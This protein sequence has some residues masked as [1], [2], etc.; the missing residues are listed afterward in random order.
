MFSFAVQNLVSLVRFHLFIFVFLSIALETD[1]VKHLYN[2]CQ[3]MF[4]PCSFLGVSWCHVLCL[5]LEAILSLF[6]WM[7]WGCVLVSLIYIQLSSF[8]STTC[9]RDCLFPILY[10]CLICWGLINHRW[11]GL[12]LGSLFCFICPYVCF[13]TSTTLSWLL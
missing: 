10:S 5:N 8:P 4:C 11:L 6:L 1:L 3:R 2:L 9:W 12:F 13:C 7:V